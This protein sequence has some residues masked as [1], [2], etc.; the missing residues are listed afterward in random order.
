MGM[1][2]Y[3]DFDSLCDAVAG[4]MARGLQAGIDRRGSASMALA[5]G[6]TPFPVYRRL[7]GLHLEWSRVRALPGDERWVPE[8]HEASNLRAIRDAFGGLPMRFGALVPE[9]P[10]GPASVD[11]ALVTLRTMPAPFDVCVLGMGSDGHFA[12]LFPNS[13]GLPQALDP[14]DRTPVVVVDPDPLPPEA[15]FSRVSLTLS[16]ILSSRHLLLLLRGESKREVL[17][18]AR[19]RDP[20]SYPIAALLDAAGAAL[21][22]HWSP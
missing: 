7:A 21:K 8:N 16:S 15:P 10:E 14:E 4:D 12:S 18:R 20:I 3:P 5:G 11:R 22:I 6:S 19:A 9:M 2:E 13:P 17:E 1:I